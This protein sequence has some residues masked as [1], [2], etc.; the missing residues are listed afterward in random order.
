MAADAA[1]D[2][3]IAWHELRPG[4]LD[5]GIFARRFSSAGVPL[6]SEFQVN[7]YT[8]NTQR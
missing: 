6:A 7:T 4:R 2:F 1:G 5:N 3:V 8:A